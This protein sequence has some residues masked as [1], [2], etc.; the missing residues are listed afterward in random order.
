MANTNSHPFFLSANQAQG[1]ANYTPAR[2]VEPSTK[3]IY[4]SGTSSRRGDGTWAGV[5]EDTDGRLELNI[6]EQTEAVLSN[7]DGVIRGATDGKGSIADIVDATIFLVNIKDDYS[8]MN[9]EWN[10]V[11]PEKTAAPARTT[12]EVRAL[13]DP[14]LLVE[15]KC[16]AV[17]SI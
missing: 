13:P 3:T 9:E 7:I 2:I 5:K 1:L 16:T 17:V 11:F 6:R 14:R 15:I 4:V 8:G 12:V 10:K